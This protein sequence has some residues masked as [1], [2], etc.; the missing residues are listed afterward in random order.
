MTVEYPFSGILLQ[1]SDYGPQTF[2][3]SNGHFPRLP[4]ETSKVTHYG[5]PAV[6]VSLF[7][8]AREPYHFL[9]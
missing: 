4:L 5:K 8:K 9:E 1:G 2:S 3:I 7:L 6:T